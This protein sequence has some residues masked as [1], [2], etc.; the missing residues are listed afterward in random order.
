MAASSR[1]RISRLIRN[2]SK[3]RRGLENGPGSVLGEAVVF[4]DPAVVI[5]SDLFV[6][7]QELVVLLSDDRQPHATFARAHLNTKV[8]LRRQAASQNE[9]CFVILCRTDK[10]KYHARPI[11]HA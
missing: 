8:H 9:D 3:P 4:I 2:S 11:V 10:L 1:N 7:L 6:G 5:V